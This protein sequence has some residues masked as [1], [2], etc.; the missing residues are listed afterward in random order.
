[1]SCLNKDTA[2]TID[3]FFRNSTFINFKIFI[4][5]LERMYN[6]ASREYIAII[7]LKNLQQRNRDFTSFFLEF[8]GFISKLD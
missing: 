5:L 4:S 2:R 3:P 1:M 6:N 7:K 8:L